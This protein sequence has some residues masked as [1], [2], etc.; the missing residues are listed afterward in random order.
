MLNIFSHQK[1]TNQKDS[2]F[3]STPDRKAKIKILVTTHAVKDM[4]QCKYSPITDGSTNLYSHF[5]NVYGIFLENWESIYL[6]I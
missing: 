1:N 2:D 5:L 3:I 6:K 4:E